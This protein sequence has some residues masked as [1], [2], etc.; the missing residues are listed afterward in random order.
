MKGTLGNERGEMRGCKGHWGMEGTW[1][2]EEVR[3]G[4]VRD[5]GEWRGHKE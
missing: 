4:D 5:I 2:M 3:G 1:R